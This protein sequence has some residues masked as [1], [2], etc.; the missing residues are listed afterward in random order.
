MKTKYR[1]NQLNGSE[2]FYDGVSFIPVVYNNAHL[3]FHFLILHFSSLVGKY[4][5]VF[6]W[7][8]SQLFCYSMWT[9]NLIC[10]GISFI[11]VCLYILLIFL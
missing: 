5:N 4:R 8:N 9:F 6:F 7:L 3:F 1:N 11:K 10:L 2:L